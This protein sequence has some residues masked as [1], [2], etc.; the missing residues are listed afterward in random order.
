MP[1]IFL[2]YDSFGHQKRTPMRFEADVFECEVQGE[3]PPELEGAYFRTGGDRQYPSLEE[4]IIL[5]GD[6]M[7]SAFWFEDG[8]VSFRSRYVQT[9]R[10]K[11]EREARRRLY[12]HYRNKHT[13]DESVE[14]HLPHG[15]LMDL[16]YDTGFADIRLTEVHAPDDDAD[17]DEVVHFATRGWARH[18]PVEEIWSARLGEKPAA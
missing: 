5:N 13:D 12:G 11:R 9:E 3:I 8:H 4:D 1:E 14:F 16:L 6:G 10:L 17:P 15:K 2:P 18:W 7:A